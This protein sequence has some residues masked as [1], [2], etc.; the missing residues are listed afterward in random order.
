MN[1]KLTV[2]EMANYL[3]VSKEAIYN[4]VRRGSLESVIED[5]RKY[6]LLTDELKNQVKQPKRGN[7][8]QNNNTE[9]IELLK[10]QIE[11][12]KVQ[13]QR[14]E[15]DKEQLIKD[16]EKML[17][18]QKEKIESIYNSRDE[19]LRTI[20]SLAN[21]QAL[22][23]KEETKEYI[24]EVDEFEEEIDIVDQ[25]C[26]SFE[27]WVELKEYL[28]IRGYSKEQKKEIKK[29]VKDKLGANK[30]IKQSDGELFIKKDKKLKNIIGK[31]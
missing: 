26:E 17:I 9:Y 20:L 14:L 25:M 21:V 23:N 16:K 30:N 2:I 8:I 5:G 22:E 3:G 4:R 11:E 27:E 7:N 29:R 28:K 1:K 19:H 31:V 18:E 6:V 13:V 10:T 15:N 12:L 24:V